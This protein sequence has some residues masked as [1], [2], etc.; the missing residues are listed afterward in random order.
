MLD[1]AQLPF[2]RIVADADDAG[3]TLARR[4]GI[5]QAP[6]LVVERGDRVDV[7]GGVAAIKQY[8]DAQQPAA[9][10]SPVAGL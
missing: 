1:A 7:Y 9:V 3:R 6:T 5:Q 8:I 4:F 10:H 2:E